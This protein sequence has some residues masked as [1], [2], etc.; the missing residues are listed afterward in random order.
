LRTQ[1]S[2]AVGCAIA[3]GSLFGGA[4]TKNEERIPLCDPPS[5]SQDLSALNDEE[6]RH[7][8]AT[9]VRLHP[10]FEGFSWDATAREVVVYVA[11][12]AT[13]SDREEIRKEILPLSVRFERPKYTM[14]ELEAALESVRRELSSIANGN[15]F[16]DLDMSRILVH[17]V[18]N[19][20][21]EIARV[22]GRLPRSSVELCVS[23]EAKDMVRI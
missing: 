5:I 7:F 11:G 17:L 3:L 15:A 8:A 21:S 18:D 23:P 13:E 19:S 16:S 14:A 20:S 4:C 6:S 1:A 22:R 9:G 2:A 12:T 10:P